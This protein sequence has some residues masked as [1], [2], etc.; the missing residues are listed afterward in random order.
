M[1][2][3]R[4]NFQATAPNEVWMADITCIPTDE[5]WL[6]LVSIIDLYSLKIVG[7]YI[8]T[9]MTKESYPSKRYN[10]L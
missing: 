9:R 2:I 4:K 10:G 1:T 5:G 7:R 8:D 3:Y 6:C